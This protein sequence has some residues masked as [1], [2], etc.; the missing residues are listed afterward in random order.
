MKKLFLLPIILFACNKQKELEV[1][2]SSET[3]SQ[4]I[5][6]DQTNS[7]EQESKPYIILIS[8]DGFRYDYAEKYGA[9]N[10]LSFDV[11]SEKMIPSFPTKTF[12]NHYAIVTGLY[13]GH[14]GLVSN[15]FYDRSLD[16]TYSP[17]NRETVENPKF[18]NGSPLWVLASEQNMVSASM[19]W[20]GSEA[21]VK[22]Y[23]PTYYF[24]YN[25]KI[26]HQDRVNKVVQWLQLPKEKRPH[27]ITLYFSIT[28]DLGHKYGPDS[29]EIKQGV[30]EIDSSIGDLVSKVDQLNL[31]VNIIVVSD[32]GMLKIDGENLIYPAKIFP[33]DMKYTASFPAMVY[34][35][36]PLRI[37]SLY[38]ALKQDTSKYSVYLKS[39][40]PR[41]LHYDQNLE[42]IG[43]LVLQP[44]PPYNFGRL[45]G[46]VSKGASTHGF[47]P[48][49]TPEMGAIFYTKGPAFKK[50]TIPPFENIHVYPMIANILGLSYLAD[51]IDGNF[52]VLKPILK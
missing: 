39:D 35:D 2:V 16:A 11:K 7:E 29:E 49:T 19:F 24:K 10:L 27:L 48:S 33:S 51:S 42:R 15:E 44:K 18:Y 46:T 3:A 40:L 50:A 13:P 9:T 30:I 38:K 32:H 31:P 45:G 43:D 41:H 22:E 17:G 47:D 6:R 5:I 21:P 4:E 23:F 20:V 8:I 14:N 37:D 25:G 52:D 26:S 12:P 36:D 34:S 1:F 28:D